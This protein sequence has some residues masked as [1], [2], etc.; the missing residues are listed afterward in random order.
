MVAGTSETDSRIQPLSYHRLSISG[1][2]LGSSTD[3]GQM[4]HPEADRQD[5]NV[6]VPKASG[7]EPGPA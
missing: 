4:M 5:Q 2:F 7:W 6:L 1:D 3:R